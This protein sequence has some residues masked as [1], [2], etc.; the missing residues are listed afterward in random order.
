MDELDRVASL[1]TDARIPV[2]ALKNA[3]ITRGIFRCLGCSPMGD[4]DLLVQRSDFAKAHSLLIGMGYVCASRNPFETG[5]LEE[6]CFSGGTEYWL[7]L[8]GAGKLWLEL[9]WRPVAG[10]WLRPDQEPS[11]DELMARSV[12][13]EGTQIRLLCPE[14]NLLQVCLHTAK[15]SFVRAPGFRLHS[16][17][18]RIVR[19]AAIDWASFV[20]T[21]ERL[22]VKTAVYLSLAIPAE[23]LGTPIPESV[24]ER[25]RPRAQQEHALRNAIK[26]AGLFHPQ[27]RKFS[28][29]A[30]IRFVAMLYDTPGGLLRA[31]IPDTAWMKR[32]YGFHSSALLPLYHARRLWSLALHRVGI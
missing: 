29:A 19:G 9:Q 6:G 4:V 12:A 30:Y 22:E 11:G 23:L 20:H 17:V 2:V 27:A 10:R 25:L 15:H 8:A 26:A 5:S 32:Q 21:A 31:V 7:E 18:D 14:D 13:I 1:L 28:N 24:L 16:D 3:G